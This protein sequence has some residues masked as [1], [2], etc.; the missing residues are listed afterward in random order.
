MELHRGVTGAFS[1]RARELLV[2]AAEPWR[3]VV[4]GDVKARLNAELG[5]MDQRSEMMCT[6]RMEAVLKKVAPHTSPRRW[7]RGLDPRTDLDRW[8]HTERL[9]DAAYPR[10]GAGDD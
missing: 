6:L 1:E 9:R 3:G 8:I 10:G 2:E 7:S 5:A 4:P